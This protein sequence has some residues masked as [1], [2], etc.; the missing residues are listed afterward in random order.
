MSR[1]G[2]MKVTYVNE[3][4][5]GVFEVTGFAEILDIG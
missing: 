1:K 3:I 5:Q 4:V 2:G